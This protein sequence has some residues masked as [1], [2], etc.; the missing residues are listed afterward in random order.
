M[1]RLTILLSFLQSLV[2]YSLT[3][4][5][6]YAQGEVYGCAK[7]KGGYLR[8]VTDPN[9]CKSN[10]TSVTMNQGGTGSGGIKVYDANRTVFRIFVRFT[11]YS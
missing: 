4:L 1:K 9:Q 3:C 8:I 5:T 2:S 11:R 7:K 6:C 10:E